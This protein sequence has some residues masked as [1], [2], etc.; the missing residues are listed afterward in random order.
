MPS[1]RCRTSTSRLT[2]TR[3]GCPGR[4]RG[5][6]SIRLRAASID[7]TCRAGENG[8]DAGPNVWTAHRFVAAVAL[9]GAGVSHPKQAMDTAAA[10]PASPCLR[11]YVSAVTKVRAPCK[12]FLRRHSRTQCHPRRVLSVVGQR[13]GLAA[14]DSIPERRL[15]A[16]FPA[17]C[18][19][20]LPESVER[21]L[22]GAWQLALIE[23]CPLAG[24]PQR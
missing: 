1:R 17:L 3:N 22:I 14:A 5:V 4:S 16:N 10:L 2:N 23:A 19:R 15:W 20:R 21:D 13:L 7:A 6:K 18:R 12:H 8:R 11:P 9:G 24:R